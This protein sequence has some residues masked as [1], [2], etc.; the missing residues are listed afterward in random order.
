MPLGSWAQLVSTYNSSSTFLVPAGVTEVTVECWGGGGRGGRQTSNGRGGGGG[1]GAYVRSTIPV[2]A[3][4]TYTVTVGAGSSSTSAGGDSWFGTSSTI[5]AKGG[6]S[7]GNNSSSGANGGSAAAS[8]GSVKYEGGDGANAPSSTGGGGGSS[9]G[10]SANGANG[11][12]QNGGN[13]PAGGG[14]GGNGGNGGFLSPGN[15]S[16][17]S[18]PGGGG[19]GAE[20]VTLSGDG[21]GGNGGDGR[22]VLTY[23]PCVGPTV[24]VTPGS[25]SICSGGSVLLTASGAS[26]GYTWSPATGLSS[27]SGATVTANPTS[28]T[29]YTVIG[30]NTGCG[31]S[32]STTVTVIVTPGPTAVTANSSAST[33]CTGGPVNLTGGATNLSSTILTN[34]FNSGL[35]TWNTTNNSSGGTPALADWTPRPDGYNVSSNTFHSND[36]SQFFLSNSDAQGSGGTTE[37]ILS[38]PSF[39]TQGYSTLSLSYYHFFRY[40][41]GTDDR[42]RVEVSTNGT[43]WTILQTHSSTQGSAG[44]FSNATVNLN[45]YTNQPTL[46]VRF[47]YNGSWDWWWAVDNAVI[48][49]TPTA[50]MW[51]WTST[52]SGYTS[53]AQSPTGVAVPASRTF[54]LTVTAGNGCTATANTGSV[55]AVPVP[56]AGG[57]GTLVTCNN[58]AP[59]NLSSQLTGSPDGGGAWSGPSTVIGGMYDP[60]TMV[61]GVYTYLVSA[62]PCTAASATVTVTENTATAWYADDDGDSFGDAGDMVMACGAPAGYVADNTDCDDSQTTYADNDGDGFG[63]GAPVACGVGNNSDCNDAAVLHADLDGDGFGAAANAPCG[64]ADNSDCDDSQALYTDNDGDG[65]GTGT[66]VACG[67]PDNTDCDDS[68]TL[69]ADTDGDGYG[70][71]A[72]AACGVT[73]NAD[74]CPTLAGLQGDYCDVNNGVGSFLFGQIN[75]S[76]ACVAVPCTE[77]VTMELRTDALSSQASWQILLQNTNQVVCQFS[78]PVNGITSPITENCCLPVGCYRLRVSDSGGDGFVSGGITGG[79]QLRES[80]AAGRRIIDNLGNFTNLAGGAPDVSA[81]ANTY[82]NGAFC[83]PVGN[84]RPIFSSCDKL[85]WVTNKFIVATE[86][87]AVSGQYGVTNNTS[88][89]EFWFFDPNGTY[90]YRRFRSHGSSDGFGVGPLRANHFR[91]NAWTNTMATPH[92]PNNVLLNVRIRGRVAG[93]NQ[94]FGPAC[95]FK[96][97]AI[98]AACP[99]V[100]LQDNPLS[101]DF[102]CGVNK[103]FGGSNQGGNRLTVNPPQP[104]PTVSSV[105]V[106]YQIRFRN[107]E[108]PNPGGCIVRPPQTSPTFFLNWS[109]ASGTQLKCNTQYD[110]DV[111]VSLDGGATW[112]VGNAS[113][114]PAL[115]CADPGDP[116]TAW[117]KVC[118]VNITTSTYCPGPMQGGSSSMATQN[119]HLTMYPN[120]NRGEQLFIN[121]TEV[122]AD[123]HTVSVDIYDMTG[124]RVTARTIAVQ[125]GF[126]NANIDLNNDLAGGLYVVNITAGE[127]TYT[128]RLVIQQ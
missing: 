125:D 32:G 29:T 95:L 83:V 40:N 75:G 73:N 30:L 102:S 36:N 53:S 47:R 60:A 2:I 35:G 85:D 100:K 114:A 51:A 22:V 66:P 107:G 9:A 98:R 119:G 50:L 7:V 76:C 8:I 37:T 113:S 117:G 112:C 26:A 97:D 5:R 87:V 68:Q 80:G 6:S 93:V 115:N 96:M 19:G 10:I 116:S 44:G 123:V 56:N 86:N 16:A 58:A 31:A 49:G 70:A 43:T 108:Y 59:S 52:P 63:A 65:F 94:P 38:T 11:S 45:A 17:G 69:Y 13:A 126:V 84:D 28:T 89:Y 120:P 18:L 121:L 62:P 25:P 81:L 54:N 57:N 74:D 109:A 48:S 34:D 71:G 33:V 55:T 61:A 91:L 105:N 92:L 4:N 21:N 127:K 99:I 88:G 64:I 90:S 46:W 128:E 39:S 24:S 41:S 1:G 14:D 15:G 20:E 67:V 101:N 12:N 106:R 3:G 122:D 104:I 27:T 72:P 77:T 78:V 82:E 110:V 103:F 79:Y 42:A 23:T 118:A 111:R 124:K